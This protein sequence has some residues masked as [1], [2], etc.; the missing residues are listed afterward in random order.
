MQRVPWFKISVALC[1]LINAVC[2]S[3]L[4]SPQRV[5]KTAYSSWMVGNPYVK[6]FPVTGPELLN[7]PS[8]SSVTYFEGIHLALKNG[9]HR[10][11]YAVCA[12][13]ASRFAR[14]AKPTVNPKVECTSR[15]RAA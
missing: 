14:R 15:S 12:P 13:G 7:T 9:K 2:V 5:N 3:V 10:G 8:Q 4:W 6:E 1:L 11:I